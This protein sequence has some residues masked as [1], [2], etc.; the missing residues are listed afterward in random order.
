[1]LIDIIL[2][3]ILLAMILSGYRKGLL[4]SLMRL[5]IVILCCLGASTAQAALTPRVTDYL[6]PKLTAAIRPAM[7]AGIRQETENALEEAGQAGLTIGGEELTLGDL[8]GLLGQFG[9]DVE[10]TVTDSTV[11]TLE[12]ALDAAAQTL[13]HVITLRVAGALIYFSAFLILSLILHNV[14]LAVNAVDRLPVIHTF[15]R[16][17]GA[18]LGLLGGLTA[19]VVAAAVCRQAELLPKHLGPFSQIIVGA[20]EHLL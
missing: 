9:L 5:I 17:G 2:L 19:M 16:M 4:M 10:Q 7:E 14:A 3:L 8:A 20:A 6:E 18:L 13:A 11:D 12:P 1:M 15:N